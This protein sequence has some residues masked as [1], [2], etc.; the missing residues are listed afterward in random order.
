MLVELSVYVDADVAASIESNAE[1]DGV[2]K[3]EYV[4]QH[5]PECDDE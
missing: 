4:R 3:S 2:S 1:E 5:L